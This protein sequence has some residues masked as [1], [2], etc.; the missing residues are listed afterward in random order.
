[1][2]SG[3]RISYKAISQGSITTKTL[4]SA[5]TI[6]NKFY[7]A[8]PQLQPDTRHV[9]DD[10][11]DVLPQAPSGNAFTACHLRFRLLRCLQFLWPLWRRFRDCIPEDGK[12]TF[13]YRPPSSQ[14]PHLRLI[15][16]RVYLYQPADRVLLQIHPSSWHRCWNTRGRFT[17]QTFSI[18]SVVHVILPNV[19]QA[20]CLEHWLE[21]RL[22]HPEKLW[23]EYYAL[24]SLPTADVE[25]DHRFCSVLILSHPISKDLRQDWGSNL[26]DSVRYASMWQLLSISSYWQRLPRRFLF[27]RSAFF[28]VWHIIRNFSRVHIFQYYRLFRCM[29]YCGYCPHPKDKS[30]QLFLS[31]QKGELNCSSLISLYIY[32]SSRSSMLPTRAFWLMGYVYNTSKWAYCRPIWGAHFSVSKT[33]WI[34]HRL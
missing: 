19:P 29:V 34:V 9:S 8:F 5:A 7:G 28:K 11:S 33:P 4:Q 16:V 2:A 1:M 17:G 6:A 15:G 20:G 32:Y 25:G 10:E 27:W 14:R 18:S 30:H 26:V 12:T 13:S 22:E 23:T 24:L 3:W 21:A 31:I